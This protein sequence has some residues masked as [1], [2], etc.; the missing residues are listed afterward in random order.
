MGADTGVFI[1]W[2][3]GWKGIGAL[4]ERSY[5]PSFPEDSSYE[6]HRELMKEA[7]DRF[8]ASQSKVVPTPQQPRSPPPFAPQLSSGHSAEQSRYARTH[9]HTYTLP[10]P[11]CLTRGVVCPGPDVDDRSAIDCRRGDR[12]SAVPIQNHE[13]EQEDGWGVHRP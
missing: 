7:V 9:I 13:A 4:Y 12:Y 8:N 2:S 3:C 10:I 1:V 6:V 11:S 5:E